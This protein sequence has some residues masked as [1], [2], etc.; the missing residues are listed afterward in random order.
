MH[1]SG[2]AVMTLG[3][4]GRGLTAGAQIAPEYRYDP[5]PGHRT[6]SPGQPQNLP[7]PTLQNG[8][9]ALGRLTRTVGNVVEVATMGNLGKVSRML[10]NVVGD[11]MGDAPA[12]P[13]PGTYVPLSPAEV[14]VYP[15]RGPYAQA[16]RQGWMPP[17]QADLYKK[18]ALV[19]LVVRPISS[20]A[21]AYHGY[22]RND[23]IGWAVWWALMGGIVP[24]IPPT[25][26]LAQGW[27]K[28]KR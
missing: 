16:V 14:G 11:D 27:G 24:F 20:T 19:M 3:R 10:G 5:M 7:R 12:P 6:A 9:H 15:G 25:I 28:R 1:E 23:S 18:I 26:G 8:P 13:A 21:S 4:L 22:K 17:D 2:T